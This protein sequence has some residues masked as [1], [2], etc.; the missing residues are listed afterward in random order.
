M[1]GRRWRA[2][3]AVMLVGLALSVTSAAARGGAHPGQGDAWRAPGPGVSITSDILRVDTGMYSMTL[4]TDGEWLAT[5]ESAPADEGADLCAW[6][7]ATWENPVCVELRAGTLDPVGAAWSPDGTRLAFTEDGFN[8]VGPADLM[9]FDRVDGTVT[10]LTNGV[11]EGTFGDGEPDGP[12][13][14]SVAWA[15]DGREIAFSLS[16]LHRVGE[17]D[18]QPDPDARPD[19]RVFRISATGGD[20]VLI[21]TA[22]GTP[23][24][25]QGRMRWQQD[26]TIL[27]SVLAGA[28]GQP[29]PTNGVFAIDAAGG[30]PRAVVRPS[31]VGFTWSAVMTDWSPDGQLLVTELTENRRTAIIDPAT[32]SWRPLHPSEPRRWGLAAAFSPDGSALLIV[33]EVDG[34][35]VMASED[36]AT[37]TRTDLAT[38]AEMPDR[39][40]LRP[41]LMWGTNGLVW[42]PSFWSSDL[43]F[44]AMTG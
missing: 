36:V 20:P 39:F 5:I 17:D 10:N 22:H 40:D 16:A 35:I 32:G 41:G 26:G 23:D 11:A 29:E 30:E 14:R 4:S 18:R 1:T 31:D 33:T 28:P 43:V 3:A 24:A 9:V 6:S 21:G 19:T 7:T 27:F 12:V 37:G 2:I 38:L 42:G 15:P 8:G 44:F 25:V 34:R 13:A